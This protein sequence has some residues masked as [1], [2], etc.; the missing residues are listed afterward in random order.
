[1][2]LFMNILTMLFMEAL[3]YNVAEPDDGEYCCCCSNIFTGS[4]WS[5]C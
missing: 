5:M 3:M 1:M 4:D 2:S